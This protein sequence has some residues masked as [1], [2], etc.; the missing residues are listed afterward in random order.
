MKDRTISL[1]MWSSWVSVKSYEVYL[2]ALTNY[3]PFLG[4]IDYQSPIRQQDL[5]KQL[6]QYTF[7]PFGCKEVKKVIILEHSH[8]TNWMEAISL[9][10]NCTVIP[11]ST[12]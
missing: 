2:I 9:G 5:A 3:C 12:L 11:E 1:T 4:Q 7:Y 8:T 6:C 10:K